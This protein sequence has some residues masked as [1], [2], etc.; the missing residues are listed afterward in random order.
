MYRKCHVK[1]TRLES[2][3]YAARQI[4]QDTVMF[5][6]ANGLKEL[7]KFEVNDF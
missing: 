1:V 3:L 4:Y 5:A 7:T 2:L 6:N